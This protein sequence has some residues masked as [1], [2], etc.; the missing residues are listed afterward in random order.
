MRAIATTVF[1]AILI[2]SQ[3]SA[4]D[5][6]ALHT[7]KSACMEGPVAQFGRYIGDWK[8]E[9]ETLAKDGSSWGP[10]KGARWIFSCVGPGIAIQDY[11]MASGGGFG[12]NLRTYNPDTGSWEIV[13]IAGNQN[14]MMHIGAQ[15]I[16]NGNIVMNILKPDQD[17]PRRIIFFPPDENGWNWVQQWSFDGGDTWID[18]YRI[19]A[20]PW[21]K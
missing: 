19:K 4:G 10:G 7:D 13:W 20:S 12:T 1:A 18:V 17:P 5:A 2:A 15:Q 8:I 6:P 21:Q 16:D 9:D 14:G 11:W 3:A